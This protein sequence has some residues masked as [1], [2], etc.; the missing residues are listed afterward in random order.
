MTCDFMSFPIVFQ[1][2]SHIRTMV[3]VCVWGR[4][5]GRWEVIAGR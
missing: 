5:G 3:G 1:S 2:Y 4:G